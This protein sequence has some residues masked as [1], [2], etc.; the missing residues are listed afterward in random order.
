MTHL[1][2]IDPP[3][4]FHT[5]LFLL[6]RE[7]R[8][9]QREVAHHAGISIN[10]Y[11]KLERGATRNPT[12]KTWQ[13]LATAFGMSVPDVQRRLIGRATSGKAQDHPALARSDTTPRML[14]PQVERIAAI[15]EGLLPVDVEFVL[16]LCM[17]LHAIRYGG[18]EIYGVYGPQQYIQVPQRKRRS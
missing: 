3:V 8:L 10:G 12:N 16:G 5:A 13:G 1:G 9:T 11:K 4:P 17:Q 7:R 14:S 2:R 15:V 6:R 18:H